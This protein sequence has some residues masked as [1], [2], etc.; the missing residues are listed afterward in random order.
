MRRAMLILVSF[1]LLLPLV[2]PVG[3][4]A[5][6]D[7]VF[8]TMYA[9][10]NL[11]FILDQSGSMRSCDVYIG[12][13]SDYD[14][15]RSYTTSDGWKTF[16]FSYCKRYRSHGRYYYYATRLESAK[17]TLIELIDNFR[18]DLNIGFMYFHQT[19][20]SQYNS[21][22]GKIV[23]PVKDVSDPDNCTDSNPNQCVSWRHAMMNSVYEIEPYGYT[24][25][26]E[27]LDTAG[28]YFTEGLTGSKCSNGP[29]PSPITA[30]CQKNFTILL[31]DGYPTSDNFE[32]DCAPPYGCE[33]Q[34]YIQ[35]LQGSCSENYD[36]DGDGNGSDIKTFESHLLDDVAWWLFNHDLRPDLDGNQNLSTYT[37][38]FRQGDSQLLQH[39][40]QVGGG[41][42]Y[43]AQNYEQLVDS[44]RSAIHYIL[45]STPSFAPIAAPK[46]VTV[47]EAYGFISWFKPYEDRRIW[48]GHM[49][50]Y[51]LNENN[52]FETDSEGNPINS[53]W[54]AG[55]V[56]TNFLKNQNLNS[57]TVRNNLLSSI[58]TYVYTK[59]VPLSEI[60]TVPGS[61]TI[62]EFYRV[63]S[64]Y[65]KLSNIP[66]INSALLGCT[67]TPNDTDLVVSCDTGG[68]WWGHGDV[69]HSNVVMVGSPFAFLRFLPLYG[70]KY[71][72][73]Y[74]QWKDRNPL[75]Y[76]GA[77]DGT[78]H[79]VTVQ[80]WENNGVTYDAGMTV[81]QF[82]PTN[83]LPTL[84]STAINNSWDYSVD[85]YITAVDIRLN[86]TSKSFEE[87]DFFTLLTFGLR[88]GGKRYYALDVTDPSNG[89]DADDNN[90]GYGRV[91]WEF[92]NVPPVDDIDCITY[93]N[94]AGGPQ[95][96]QAGPPYFEEICLPPP[97]QHEWY[98]GYWL[99][100][101]GET[102]GKP[103]VG[104][105][106]YDAGNGVDKIYAVFATG[107]YPADFE[108]SDWDNISE[109]A[110]L[111]I[112]DASSG[113]VIKAFVNSEPT[114]TVTQGNRTIYLHPPSDQYEVVD[115]LHSLVGTPTVVDLNGDGIIETVY[116]GDIKGNIW[117][118]DLSSEDKDN[119]TMGKLAELGED[120]P[121]FQ[122]VAVALD[123]CGR[124]WVFAGTGR[125]DEPKNADN[126]WYMVGII[127]TTGIPD[128]PVTMDDLQDISSILTDVEDIFSEENNP[129]SFTLSN[130]S[131]GWKL[132]FPDT[133]EKLFEDPFV[134]GDLYFTTYSPA[135][136]T[137]IC[138][139][140]GQMNAYRISLPGCGGDVSA[141][142]M[143]GRVSGGGASTLGGYEVYVTDSTPGSK[144]IIKQ[145]TLSLPNIFGPVYWRLLHEEE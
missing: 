135:G 87:R 100:F 65:N 11:L 48:E 70:N 76:Y 82:V 86:D 16:T 79:V 49:E 92:P 69:F 41:Q 22:G 21:K 137:D 62:L 85:G 66:P 130:T 71:E 54:D 109:G 97:Y 1:A 95:P 12:D 14:N 89:L 110:G 115:D 96:G 17:R 8:F 78:L 88:Q 111:F 73:F 67:L 37:I 101:M 103:K 68:D 13:Q 123:T 83:T 7:R 99:P 81:R 25:L 35:D 10:P 53:V 129:P 122:K 117:K 2:Y 39:A 40:A 136:I 142:R 50:A 119:W 30:W 46:T 28:K 104:L 77:N 132:E 118:V 57:S 6:D 23:Y 143:G 45:Q 60:N 94:N 98:G 29:C 75:V 134:F 72:E 113:A 121:I 114:I 19:G 105:L 34:A 74:N 18:N 141:V 44:I 27:T 36:L 131:Q 127:D 59:T 108:P 116:V 91:L 128:Q 80:Q 93:W 140:G 64:P 56:L 32:C 90:Q 24:P 144:K 84:T 20:Y 43:D 63:P 112:L 9:K 126:S 52:E 31:T 55:L 42:Y 5:T 26:A 107:G 138:S 124:R 125:R 139:A 4:S 38:K 3:H 61:N 106:S 145:K 15:F 51:E 58:Y 47:G 120:Q 33:Y 102:W 133:G